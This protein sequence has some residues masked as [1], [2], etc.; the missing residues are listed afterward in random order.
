MNDPRSSHLAF[1]DRVVLFNPLTEI[2]HSPTRVASS[3]R[4]F[5]R[6]NH[7]DIALFRRASLVSRRQP[8]ML[9]MLDPLESKSAMDAMNS[10]PIK[11]DHLALH[12]KHIQTFLIVYMA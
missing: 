10:G 6:Q 8:S 2:D 5:S 11:T 12:E 4:F 7:R 9:R 3:V 1:R